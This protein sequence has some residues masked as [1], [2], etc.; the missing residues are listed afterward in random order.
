MRQLQCVPTT[1][2]TENKETYFEIYTYQ[3][4]CP[5][6]LLLSNISSCQSVLKYLSQY[7]IC[8]YLHDSSIT[9]FY[10]KNYAFAKLVL[11]W[12]YH[13]LLGFKEDD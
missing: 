10:I 6:A 5:L 4:S 9:K 1:Y 3:E 11:A 13:L 8:L 12:L 2:I 7:G